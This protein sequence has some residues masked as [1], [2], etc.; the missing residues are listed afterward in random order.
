[1]L[2]DDIEGIFLEINLRKTK[3]LLCATYH[4]PS[5]TDGYFFDHLERALDIYTDFYNNFL[6]IGDFNCEETE[7]Q[8]SDFLNQYNAKNL[9]K[10]KTCFKSI[11]NPSCIDLFITNKSSSF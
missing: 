5:Q 7:P 8:L 2:P 9:V 4:R 3:W 6:L 11:D 10:E 1:M